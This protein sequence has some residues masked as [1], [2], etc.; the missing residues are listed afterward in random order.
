MKD[1]DKDWRL[2]YGDGKQRYNLVKKETDENKKLPYKD[3]PSPPPWRKFHEINQD[4]QDEI[5]QRWAEIQGLATSEENKR[6]RERGENFRIHQDG[7]EQI[8]EDGQG[9]IN[10][11]NAALYLRRPLLV[12]GNPGSGKTS[13]AYAIAHELNLGPVLTWSIT[14]R[15]TLQDGLYRYDAIGRLQDAEKQSIGDYITLGPLGTAFL[16]SPLPRVLL[17]DEIDKSDINLPN[18]L[19]HIFEEGAFNIPELVRRVKET[20]TETEKVYT[21]DGEIK[22]TIRRGRVRCA[23]FPIVIMTS[24]GEREFPPAFLRRC[25]RVK[26]PDPQAEALKNIIKAHFGQEKF[27]QAETN[28]SELIKDFLQDGDRATDQ[29]LNAIYLITDHISPED[30]D[31]SGLKELLFKSLSISDEP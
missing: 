2:F 16:P 5:K 20:H 12:T 3:F 22:A 14:T 9:V 11:V 8:T 13:L 6:G 17:I 15:S 18:D 28:I 21:S 19:L 30:L 29:L 31:K 4:E 25:L 7:Q 27:N 23:E 1:K 26:M 24:N 10:A